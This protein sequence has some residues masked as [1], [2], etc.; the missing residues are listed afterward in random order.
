[1]N[2]VTGNEHNIN[3]N[4]DIA[5]HPCIILLISCFSQHIH[6]VRLGHPWWRGFQKGCRHTLPSTIYVPVSNHSVCLHLVWME[7]LS[8]APPQ[9]WLISSLDY[10]LACPRL[11]EGLSPASLSVTVNIP[12]PWPAGGQAYTIN[13][14]QAVDLPRAGQ[15][16][17]DNICLVPQVCLFGPAS[18]F[19]WFCPGAR[20]PGVIPGTC[21]PKQINFWMQRN[22]HAVTNK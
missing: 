1:M 7:I 15:Q 19:V 3:F 6:K 13:T 16:G 20:G 18:L 17:F 5:T 9:C 10:I 4:R 21:V 12:C 2:Q 22:K 11:A 8:L 14:W